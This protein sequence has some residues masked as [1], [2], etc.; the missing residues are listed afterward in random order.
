[1]GLAGCSAHAGGLDWRRWQTAGAESGAGGT[2]S[3]YSAEGR[4]RGGRQ[5]ADCGGLCVKHGVLVD[6]FAM[7]KHG[8]G[9]A[10]VPD[11]S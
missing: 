7:E 2:G 10:G 6:F 3:R 8:V 9:M 4:R 11:E 1:V 5:W